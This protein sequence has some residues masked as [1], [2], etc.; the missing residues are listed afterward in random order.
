MTVKE[1][2]EALIELD[3]SLTVIVREGKYGYTIAHSVEEGYFDRTTQDFNFEDD[4]PNSIIV[5]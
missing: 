2:I 3:P 4:R 1:L 5:K